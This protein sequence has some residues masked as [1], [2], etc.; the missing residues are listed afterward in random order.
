[1]AEIIL[2]VNIGLLLSTEKS[3]LC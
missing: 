3:K 2:E 1:M